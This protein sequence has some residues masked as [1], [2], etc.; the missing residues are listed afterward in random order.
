MIISVIYNK[1]IRNLKLVTIIQIQKIIL[2]KNTK[3]KLKKLKIPIILL[4]EKFNKCV[5]Y[6]VNYKNNLKNKYS[7]FINYF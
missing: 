1:S 2:M 6:I 3:K 7:F 5:S 4:N